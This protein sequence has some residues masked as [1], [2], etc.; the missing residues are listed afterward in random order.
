VF[1]V[2]KSVARRPKTL[3][4]TRLQRLSPRW[5]RFVDSRGCC[6]KTGDL[7]QAYLVL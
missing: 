7:F 1:D 6:R 2:E 5:I 3:G 4:P